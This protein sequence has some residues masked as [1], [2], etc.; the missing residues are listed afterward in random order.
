MTQ[1][2][3]E[4]LRTASGPDAEAFLATTPAE[5]L[6]DAIRR[7]DDDALRALIG[8]DEIRLAA[9]RGVLGRL[10]EYADPTRLAVTTGRVRVDLTR[11][12]HRLGVHLLV[13]DGGRID[14]V[15]D[16]PRDEPADVVLA[17]TVIGF[18]R[19]VSG[20][21][22]AALDY[23]AGRLSIAGD[24]ALALAL[25]SLFTIP[26]TDAVA[27]DPTALDPV[28]VSRALHGVST[29]HLREVM[30]SGFRPIVLGEIFRRLP[31]YVN[32][33]R[34]AR[35]EL[36]VGFRLLG[37]PDGEPERYVVR[38]DHG[39]ATVDEEVGD[40][41]GERHATITCEG[42]DFLRLATG[43][44]KAVTGVLRGQLKVK[45]DKAK[46]LQFAGMIDFPA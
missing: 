22:D 12:D 2:T 44:L 45:G 34:A 18:I 7:T 38:I 33:R 27:V 4:P 17:T 39:V 29:E 10:H 46:A 13:L 19:L 8:R 35:A 20:Q 5:A 32:P 36:V 23:L 14:V 42:Y 37:A 25:G 41:R 26:G 30:A 24:C 9:V 21:G 43:H 11:D 31:G 28:D 15:T 3:L 16:V 40:G 6:V 1:V